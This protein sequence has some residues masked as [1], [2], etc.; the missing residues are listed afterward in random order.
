MYICVYIYVCMYVCIKRIES[1]IETERNR[2]RCVP[3]VAQCLRNLTK[4]HEVAG[5]IHGLAQ[6]VKYPAL[7]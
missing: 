1:A 2:G 3:I 7:P 6:E 4:N 5:S